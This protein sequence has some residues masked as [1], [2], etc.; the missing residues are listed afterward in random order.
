MFGSTASA[1]PQPAGAVPPGRWVA[2]RG[3]LVATLVVAALLRLWHLFSLRELPIFDVLILDSR[4]YDAWAQRIVA[5]DWLSRTGVGSGAF[6]MDPLYP[7]F[8]AGLYRLF[9]RDLVLVRLVQVALGVGTCGLTAIIGRRTGGAWVGNVAAL[10]VALYRPLIFNEVE[11]EKTALGVFLV[12]AA[13]AL[14]LRPGLASRAAAGA[15]MGLASL[16]RGNVLLLAPLAAVWLLFEAAPKTGWRERLLGAPGRR[17]AALL[18]AFGAVLAPVTWRNHHVSGE[19]I[20]TTYGGGANLYLGHNP[21]NRS[22]GFEHL[23]FVRSNPEYEEVDFRAAAEARAGRTLSAREVSAY[24]TREALAHIAAHPLQTLKVTWRKWVL[25]W[26]DAELPDGWDLRFLA[27]FS[28]PLAWPLPT[29]A[30]LLPLAAVG[31]AVEARARREARLLVGFVALYG[32]AV[33]LFIVFSRYRAHVVPAL[34]VLAALGVAHLLDRARVRDYRR[35]A[36]TAVAAALVLG[37]SLSGRRL[38]D[39]KRVD[40][41]QQYVD[42]AAIYFDRGDLVRAGDVV[43]RAVR[44]H[45]ESPTALCALGRFYLARNEAKAAAEAFGRCVQVA[46]RHPDSWYF[47]GQAREGVGDPAGAADAYRK[48]LELIPGHRAARDRLTFLFGT[49]P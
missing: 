12:T 42:L 33:T 20:L 10:A 13:L 34:A 45:P 2:S 46:P 35:L 41:A 39:S 43:E 31:A 29:L 26:M 8:L 38:T 21:L 14:L 5:G 24:W 11:L 3:F 25:F 22:G 18:L 48:Q 9:G 4:H 16:T 1:T 47:L 44:E 7:Y 32:G 28:P 17:A 49:A 6:Y 36:L 40:E 30:W 15:L 23:P 19:W 27:R 37:F